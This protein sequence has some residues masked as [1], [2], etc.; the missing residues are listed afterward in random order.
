[1]KLS[2]YLHSSIVDVLKCYGDLDDV[3]NKI[4][5][6]GAAGVFDVMN[7]PPCPGRDGAGRYEIDIVEPTY[8]EMLETYSPFS[9]KISLRRLLYWFVENE[10]YEELGWEQTRAYESRNDILLSKKVANALSEL[11]IAKRYSHN[12]HVLQLLCTECENIKK[13]QEYL[14]DG[15]KYIK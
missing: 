12:R 1:M 13:I 11:E 7:K 9:S 14:R 10:I 3:V 2:I 6:Q 15:G 5:E 8:L 4:L